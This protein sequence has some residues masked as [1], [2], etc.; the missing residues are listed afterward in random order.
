MNNMTQ[1]L[2]AIDAVLRESEIELKLSDIVDISYE[3]DCEIFMHCRND[4][5]MFE[6][7]IHA[8]YYPK[9]V[10]MSISEVENSP[11]SCDTSNVVYVNATGEIREKVSDD[12]L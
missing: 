7:E 12:L 9:H 5:E 2:K 4:I 11:H 3:N 6:F 8:A 10:S 1:I